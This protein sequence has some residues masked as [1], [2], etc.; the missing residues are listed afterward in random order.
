[1]H[2]LLPQGYWKGNCSLSSPTSCD[3]RLYA[4]WL[5]SWIRFCCSLGFQGSSRSP[6][7]PELHWLHYLH[8]QMTC[9]FMQQP[10]IQYPTLHYKGWLFFFEYCLQVSVPLNCQS[11]GSWC[12]FLTICPWYTCFLEWIHED[13]VALRK[14]DLYHMTHHWYFVNRL[15]LTVLTFVWLNLPPSEVI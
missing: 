2:Q 14:L 1:M 7:S 3:N 11:Q 15:V 13:K 5:I 4:D 10:A 9:T 6:L 8:C 12:P